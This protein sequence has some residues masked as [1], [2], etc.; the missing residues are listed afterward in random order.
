VRPPPTTAGPDEVTDVAESFVPGQIGKLPWNDSRPV[1]DRPI[2]LYVFNGHVFEG[3]DYE[4]SKE[5]EQTLLRNEDVVELAGDFAC[6]KV[7]I[8]S[9]A[10]LREVAGREAVTAYLSASMPR[11]EDRRVGL[12]FL[13][14]RGELISKLT[15]AKLRKGAPM[16][17]QAMLQ[18]KAE[19]AQRRLAG[20][21]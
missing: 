19:N 13:D 21:R 4:Y 1:G 11:P 18:A 8:D 15:A 17:R 14:G 6:E 5:L 7:C 2:L 9:H 3:E 10:F 20:A 12:Y 16:L